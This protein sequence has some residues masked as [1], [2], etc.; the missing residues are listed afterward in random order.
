MSKPVGTLDQIAEYLILGRSTATGTIQNVDESLIPTPP[1]MSLADVSVTESDGAVQ[2]PVHFDR[3]LEPG[4]RVFFRMR[5][6][7]GSAESGSDFWRLKSDDATRVFVIE[8][9]GTDQAF[10]SHRLVDDNY[11]EGDEQFVLEIF[12]VDG[13]FL[14]DGASTVTIHDDDSPKDAPYVTIPWYT[15]VAEGN[16]AVFRCSR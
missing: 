2:V 5:L 16:H 11:K 7:D 3:P 13:A 8:G 9:N 15:A 12:N 10:I 6:L 4:E 1:T 14:A